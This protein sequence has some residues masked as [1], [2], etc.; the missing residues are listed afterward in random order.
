[1]GAE[2]A[3]WCQNLLATRVERGYHESSQSKIDQLDDLD[4]T[5]YTSK[6][7]VHL[8]CLV[9][10]PKESSPGVRTH[11]VPIKLFHTNQDIG[12]VLSNWLTV[13]LGS[14]KL[15]LPETVFEDGGLNAIGP[16]LE[17][18]K[19][20]ELSGKRLVVRLDVK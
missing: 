19:R 1:M 15:K 8:V 4:Y 7:L 10:F 3:A 18:I 9:G 2:T 17:K 16:G 6:P 12:N 20:G 5:H 14:R 13:L 11:Q